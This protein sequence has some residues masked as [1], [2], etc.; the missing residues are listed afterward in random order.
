M[1]RPRA[2][3]SLLV[4]VLLTVTSVTAGAA[5]GPAMAAGEGVICSGG[6]V[7][8]LKVDAEGNPVGPG[9]VCLD[10]VLSLLAAPPAEA[11]GAHRAADW[12]LQSFDPSPVMRAALAAPP[13]ANARAPPP[14]V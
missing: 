11:P 12:R 4:A 14:A 2:L 9:H 13:P 6:Q 3:V 1:I 7:L 5:R 10:C 8:T